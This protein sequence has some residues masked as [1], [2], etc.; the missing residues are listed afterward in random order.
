MPYEDFLEKK[1]A[2]RLSFAELG[3]IIGY[4]PDAIKKWKKKGVVPRWME[5]VIA[6][7]EM[8]KKMKEFDL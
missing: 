1:A 7:V 2:L 5:I 4:T 8:S 6:Y 3:E